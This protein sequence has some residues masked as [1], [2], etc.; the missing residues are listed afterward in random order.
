MPAML[1]WSCSVY[2]A[3]LLQGGRAPAEGEV[4]S[5]LGSSSAGGSETGG[6]ESGGTSSFA[7]S[8][9][10]GGGG[11]GAGRGG[12]SASGG[13]SGS[14]GGG[15]EA[16]AL[17]CFDGQGPWLPFEPPQTFEAEDA[18]LLGGAR[19]AKGGNGSTG[20]GWV[21]FEGREGGLEWDI[22]VKTTGPYRLNWR[23]TAMEERDMSLTVNCQEPS[24]TVQFF[25]TGS[26]DH[27]WANVNRTLTLSSG[28]N[29][30]VFETNSGSGPNFD[31]LEII[32][33]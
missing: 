8:N 18:L 28:K 1:A 26:W 32:A 12:S 29:R 31:T 11:S 15:G 4:L 20:T 14:A 17:A 22:E 16:N 10:S 6:D 5:G 27:D 25:S 7:G 19:V 13:A 2:D 33:L 24:T 21:D 30:I 23:Y 3:S 9:N